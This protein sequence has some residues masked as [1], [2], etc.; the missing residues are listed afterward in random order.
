MSAL[1]LRPR[2]P[3]PLGRFWRRRPE[4]QRLLEAVAQFGCLR[5]Q[6]I[7]RCECCR[8][9]S[10]LF[11]GSRSQLLNLLL[12]LLDPDGLNLLNL[13]KVAPKLSCLLACTVHLSV[14]SVLDLARMN[15][16]CLLRG[17][18]LKLHLLESR[19]QC[20]GIVLLLFRASGGGIPL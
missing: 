14:R 3:R 12:E 4:H 20:R 17:R 6:R 9:L 5:L 11:C 13:L 16:L 15:R 18:G 8:Q 10:V 7:A 19:P 2:T 1:A